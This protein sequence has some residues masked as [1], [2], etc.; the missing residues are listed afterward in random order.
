MATLYQHSTLAAL[1]ASLFKGTLTLEELLKNGDTGIGTLEGVNGELVILDGHV[2]HASGD[3]SIREVTDLLETVPFA[4]VHFNDQTAKNVV[5]P[6]TNGDGL[7]KFAEENNL[8]NTFAAFNL[9][10]EFKHVKVRIAPAST[11]PYPTLAEVAK[12]QPIFETD[13]VTGTI[14]GYFAPDLFEG[15]T[16]AGWHLH[17]LSD[18]HQ[19]GGHLLLCE[20][21]ELTGTVQV[22]ENLDLHFPIQDPDFMEHNLNLHGLNESIQAAEGMVAE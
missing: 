17:F 16:A 6:P 10:G 22:F 21:G 5:V 1:M 18:D 9:H 7:Q 19:F 8:L 12:N 2:Y 20:T 15:A 11:A 13:N 3:G 4:S 14:V